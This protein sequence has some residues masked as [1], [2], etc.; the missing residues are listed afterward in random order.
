[1]TNGDVSFESLQGFN[2]SQCAAI[3]AEH[4]AAISN[5]YSP[6]DYTQLPS[7]LP[8]ARPPQVEEYE[9][10]LR[11]RKLKK[12]KSTLPLDIPDKIRRECAH[13]L[14][15][16]LTDI[17]NNSLTWSQ[18]PSVW[19]QE[20]VTPAPKVMYPKQISELRKIL[21]TSDYSKVFESFIKNWI[22]EDIS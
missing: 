16:P 12:T 18:Y 1:M 2:N 14:A 9:V 22:M 5:Q 21:S 13:F 17:I 11:L 4:F 15:G 20:R 19:K 7:Y 3:I 10:Y 8:A 6:I